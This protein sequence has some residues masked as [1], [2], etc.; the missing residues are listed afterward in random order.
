MKVHYQESEKTAYRM[1]EN[2]GK[3]YIWYPEYIKTFTTQQQKTN[4]QST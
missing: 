1:R 2:F 3:S 4:N